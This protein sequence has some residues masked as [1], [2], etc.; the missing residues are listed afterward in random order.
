MGREKPIFVIEMIKKSFQHLFGGSC[1]E[2]TK[3]KK[4]KEQCKVMT[5]KEIYSLFF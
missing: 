4:K 1:S 5:F 3:L 2:N